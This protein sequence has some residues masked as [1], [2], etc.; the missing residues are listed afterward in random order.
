MRFSTPAH[1]HHS[2][3]RGGGGRQ[4]CGINGDKVDIMSLQSDIYSRVLY[5][6]LSFTYNCLQRHRLMLC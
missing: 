6:R 1:I 3:Q 2:P 4:C 5:V